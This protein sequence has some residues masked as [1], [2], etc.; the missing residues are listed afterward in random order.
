MMPYLEYLGG[1]WLENTKIRRQKCTFSK[2]IALEI[3][4]KKYKIR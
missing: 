4:V 3:L 1:A 2:G